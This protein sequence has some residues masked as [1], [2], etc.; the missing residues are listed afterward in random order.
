[1]GYFIFFIPIVLYIKI[2]KSIKTP[3]NRFWY[4][5]YDKIYDIFFNFLT[6]SK[7]SNDFQDSERKFHTKVFSFV[8]GDDVKVQNFNHE[9]NILNF[10]KNKNLLTLSKIVDLTGFSEERA[11]NLIIEMVIKY[12]GDIDV[13][14]NGIIFYTFENINITDDKNSEFSFCWSRVLESPYLNMNSIEENKRVATLNLYN[15]FISIYLYI[16]FSKI[17]VIQD[18][19]IFF[20][21]YIF[22]MIFSTLFYLIPLVRRVNHIFVEKNINFR[23]I[24]SKKIKELNSFAKANM[25]NSNEFFNFSE[26]NIEFDN[27][28]FKNYP[29]LLAKD[30]NDNSVV[31]NIKNYKLEILS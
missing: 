10:Y 28:F 7:N 17:F 24:I 2:N 31:F 18:S 25:G 13:N 1:V 9:E 21:V 14:E 15:F 23:N 26:K 30:F 19:I 11:K 5:L 20:F 22:P 4:K 6:N 16:Y 3:M 27:Y 29:N 12:D 8:F